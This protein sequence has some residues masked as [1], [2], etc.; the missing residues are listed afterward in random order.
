MSSLSQKSDFNPF[1]GKILVT[2]GAGFIG[3]ALV[4][5]LNQ[6]GCENILITDFFGR[7]DK[8]KNLRA[9]RFDDC[10][11][12]DR[13]FSDIEKKPD[14]YGDFDAVFHLGACSSTTETDVA[15]LLDN[16]YKC[17]RRISEWALS[18]G[19]RFVYASSAATYGDGSKGLDDKNEE[20]SI[21]RPLNPYGYSKQ[22][23]DVYAQK[24]GLL[25]KIVG[26][27]YFNVF[28]PNEYHKGDMRSLVCKAYEQIINT[29]MIQLFKSYRSEYRDG[30]Q[31]RDFVYIRDAI[32]MTLH[33]ASSPTANGLFNVG[34]GI[35]RS[36]LDLA[37]AIFS[38][39]EMPPNIQFIEMPEALRAQYQY[40][41][42][43]D[44][45]KI[46]LTGY[47]RTTTSLEDA[48]RE[49]VRVYLS[50]GIRL[51]EEPHV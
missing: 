41:T 47:A 21:Y 27:K 45:S 9:L 18:R 14:F 38:A 48:I 29:G 12:A 19:S 8:W 42:L 31:K 51:G 26:I 17:T 2:G 33:L 40:Y 35:A 11:S 49:Y 50:S 46:R 20:I 37:K 16:N 43:A 13:F 1:C 22:L 7:D 44:I 5:A 30:E 10:L 3:S 32:D 15:Y 39:L 34:G 4:Y 23:F 24:K 28:G 36:W 25:A 6:R